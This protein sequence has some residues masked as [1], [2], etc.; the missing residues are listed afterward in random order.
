MNKINSIVLQSCAITFN[1][2]LQFFVLCYFLQLV[3][4]IFF[5]LVGENANIRSNNHFTW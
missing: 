4:T 3:V 5:P 2:F 1:Q